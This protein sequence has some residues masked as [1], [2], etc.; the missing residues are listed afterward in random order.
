MSDNNNKSFTIVPL[1]SS[2]SN[3]VPTT[4]TG[5]IPQL[6]LGALNESGGTIRTSTAEKMQNV[7][8]AGN[9]LK[10]ALSG[11][12]VSDSLKRR[13]QMLT[14]LATW[15]TRE[16]LPVNA[17]T[18][19]LFVM[20]TN[21][22]IQAQ[23]SYAKLLSGTMKHLGIHTLPLLT[24]ATALRAQGAA[25]PMRQALPIPKDILLNWAFKQSAPLMLACLI[26]WKTASRWSE[27]VN[28]TRKHFLYLSPNEVIIDW[29]TIPKARRA[30]PYKASK[31]TVIRGDLT[32]TIFMMSD[33][34]KPGSILCGVNTGELDHLWASD[35]IMAKYSAHSIK[36]GALTTLTEK[37]L[38]EK[39]DP[40]KISIL[41]KHQHVTILA[42][43][44]IRYGANPIALARLLGT[45]DV[46]LHL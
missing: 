5:L 40:V 45:G 9:A 33:H 15:C 46:T 14:R 22:S 24:L 29:S 13:G 2:P 7:S 42:Q 37:A 41:A 35:P 43:T 44:T 17:E 4:N 10:K 18:A 34:L 27:V 39:F 19:S 25:I 11:I 6:L 30:D 8:S 20:A 21:T 26:A 31:F 32:G 36:R 38:T 1:N 23:Y 3:V 28:L 12:W 16:M